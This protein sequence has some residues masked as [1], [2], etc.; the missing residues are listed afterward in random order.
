MC[1][2]PSGPTARVQAFLGIGADEPCL[3]LARRTWSGRLDGDAERL[4]LSRRALQPRRPLQGDGRSASGP[5]SARSQTGQVFG[6]QPRAHDAQAEG[7]AG[8]ERSAEHRRS[9]PGEV[10]ARCAPPRRARRRCRSASTTPRGGGSTPATRG[11]TQALAAG[12][13]IYGVNTGFGKL[14]GTRIGE[15]DLA[16]LQRNLILSHCTGSGPELGDEVIR[17]VLALKV[18]G[19]ARGHSGVR[20]E[21]VAMLAALLAHGVY[22]CVPSKGSVGASG[23]L[24]PLAHLSAILI[25]VGE[26]THRGRRMPA[27]EALAIA[28]LA[29]IALGPKEGLALING[30]QV[31]TALA[32]AGLFAAE[33]VFAAAI[34]AGAL[35]VEA[36]RGS[37]VPFDAR[38]HA[39]RGHQGQIDVAA[40]FR[41]LFDGSG[42]MAAHGN[43]HRVQDPYS[44]RCQPQVMGAASTRCAS[45]R[46][47]LDDRGQRRLRQPDRSS[48]TT[49]TCSPAAISTPSRWRSA[50]TS[51]AIAL[52]EIGAM[53]ERRI[54][55]LVDASLCGLPPF[56]VESSGLNSGFM[57]AQISAAALASE[58]KSLAHPA[59][60]DSIPTAANQEDHVCMATFAARRLGEI[61]D[62]VRGIVA[63]ELIAAAQ[64]LDFRRPL[65]TSPAA[66]G[67]ACADPR[68]R[69]ALRRGPPLRRGHRRGQGDDRGRRVHALRGGDPAEPRSLILSLDSVVLRN[70]VA[71]PKPRSRVAAIPK[72]A[73]KPAEPDVQTQTEGPRRLRLALPR[74]GGG[75][76]LD[77]RASP[78]SS[79]CSTRRRSATPARSTRS[80]PARCRS[81]S[82]RR[83]RPCPSSRTAPSSTA[84]P[85][86]GAP[87]PTPT[88]PTARWSRPRTCGR[89][90]RRSRRRCPPSP[91][92]SCSGRRP[93]RRSR[94]A[95]SAPMTSPAR[96]RLVELAERPVVDPPPR[97]RRH[98]RRRPR[99]ARGRVRQGHL[100]P[101]A[102]PRPR[103]P[104]RHAAAM[105][106][107]SAGFRSGR[108]TRPA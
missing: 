83:P 99:G 53:S 58:N 71:R 33:D 48:P 76:D 18:I 87:R 82:A 77:G 40:A 28:G 64:G 41:A 63:I 78:R 31:S 105:S 39:V 69:R 1:S 45:W 6:A 7:K 107:R 37:S 2:T 22:P 20:R 14:A 55:F 23:D 104:A 66:R 56:L 90:A 43:R 52:S 3:L 84:S 25:G 59:S 74:Q 35:S 72:C 81:R 38:I 92:R 101:L 61:A 32:L 88:T 47:T 95:A 50:P 16:T 60:V 44:L 49:A 67:G 75:P 70:S 5:P 46:E 9:C 34:V 21:I 93:S 42:I 36:A 91:A 85:S 51:L 62:N 98:A 96:A 11:S 13:T 57:V 102:R 106:R 29:P 17:L 100:C 19:L 97:A 15:A 12:R 89:R 27:A 68:A 94:S 86:A 24:T 54:A 30:T 8:D 79:G 108:S 73:T 4:H 80:P 10:A 103:P 65:K 26:A